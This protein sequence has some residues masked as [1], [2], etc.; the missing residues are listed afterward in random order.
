MSTTI[1]ELSLSPAYR[2]AQRALALWLERGRGG[3][4]QSGFAA[5]VALSGLDAV[6]RGRI[7]RWLAWLEVA[8][9]SRGLA[10]PATRVLRLDASLHQAMQDAL[11]RLPG[12]TAVAHK[13]NHRRS[14]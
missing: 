6:E 2:L 1:S 12:Q 5:R 7:A 9:Q 14:A 10:S 3:A 11:A 8:A 13:G 4:R